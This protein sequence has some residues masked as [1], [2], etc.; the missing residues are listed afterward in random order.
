M[1][2]SLPEDVDEEQPPDEEPEEVDPSGRYSRYSQVLGRGAFKTG[3]QTFVGSLRWSLASAA[4]QGEA[5]KAQQS[6]ND[7]YW[8]RGRITR[9]GRDRSKTF[10]PTTTPRARLCTAPD[11]V[12]LCFASQSAVLSERRPQGVWRPSSVRMEVVLTLPFNIRSL[13]DLQCTRPS[14]RR[15]ARRW[16]GT[17]RVS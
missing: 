17:R 4:P 5:L 1:E 15:R 3:E 14:T 9:P 2:A 13:F 8:E 7:A 11:V 6:R 10:A 12:G 16:H